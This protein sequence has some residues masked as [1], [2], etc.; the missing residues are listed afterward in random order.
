MLQASLKCKW[1]NLQDYIKLD[2]Y[3][4]CEQFGGI[5]IKVIKI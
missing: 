1:R 5:L 3:F 2:L 4:F